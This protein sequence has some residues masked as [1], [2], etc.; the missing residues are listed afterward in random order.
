[1]RKLIMKKI[2]LTTAAAAV[3]ASSSAFAMEDKFY[4]KA[5]VSITKMNKSN[6]L[7]SK[8][9]FLAGIGAGYY[10]M[11]EARVGLLYSHYFNPD[12]K[13]KSGTDVKFK[14]EAKS[15]LVEGQY[16]FFEMNHIK[17]FAGLGLGVSMVSAKLADNTVTPAV[18]VK[19]KQKSNFAWAAMLGAS[20]EI[21]SGVCAELTYSYRDLGKTKK[22]SST[23]STYNN[24]SVHYKGHN[25]GLGIRFDI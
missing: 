8:S 12:H 14:G 7:N 24:K 11:D 1:M 5:Q 21:T 10:V 9:S 25:I 20:T 22:F 4:G 19:A 6:S 13:A 2:L 23:T 3:L 17:M 15:L 16:D 18:S